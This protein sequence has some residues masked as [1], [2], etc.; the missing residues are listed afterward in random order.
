MTVAPAGPAAAARAWLLT[1]AV[2]RTPGT[3]ERFCSEIMPS[4][5]ERPGYL[6]AFVLLDRAAGAMR[7]LSF[8]RS[9]EELAGS[10][11]LVAEVA[12]LVL[13]P[14]CTSLE[15]PWSYDVVLSRFPMVPGQARIS[16]AE[17]PVA[18]VSV[19]EGGSI[20]DPGVVG[21]L[22]T[23]AADLVPLP[24]CAGALVLVDP[25]RPRLLGA[26][27]WTDRSGVQRTA[28]MAARNAATLPAATGSVF[29]DGGTY[30]V[31]VIEPMP[32]PV[33]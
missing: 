23:Y 21:T 4:V 9:H 8:W 15:G 12:D 17:R 20:A 26:S 18:R 22:S 13:G 27:F 19:A 10:W 14:G 2:L 30:D 33:G 1:G 31:L 3:A 32:R 29:A 16:A 5:R 6:G 7:G 11:G 28:E 25:V 24:G